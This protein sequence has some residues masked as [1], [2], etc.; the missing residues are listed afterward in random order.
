MLTLSSTP[1]LGDDE[2]LLLVLTGQPPSALGH[3][4]ARRRAGM[5][6]AVFLGRDLLARIFHGDDPPSDEAILERF[7]ID[8]GR[9]ITRRGDETIEAELRLVDDLI[10]PGNRLFITSE[11][12]VYDDFNIGL[13]IVFRF[14]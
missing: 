12:D 11:K 2:L 3:E 13:K 4:T 1:P 8:V 6:M 5:N 7:H 9:D 14:R 10:R